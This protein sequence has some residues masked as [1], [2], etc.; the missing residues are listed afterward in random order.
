M[1]CQEQMIS[2]LVLAG[3]VSDLD[4]ILAL[5]IERDQWAGAVYAGNAAVFDFIVEYRDEFGKIPSE[6]RVLD[7]FPDFFFDRDLHPLD[8]VI[9]QFHRM[10]S[11]NLI[12]DA[13]TERFK[14]LYEGGDPGAELDSLIAEL[15]S[16]RALVS[17]GKTGRRLT[18][19]SSE[20]IQ[21]EVVTWFWS[22]GGV[23]WIP[24]ASLVV[25]AGDPGEGKGLFGCWLCSMATNGLEGF[26]TTRVGILGHED[27]KGIQR[28]RLD[29]AQS[30]PVTF[31][32]LTEA[33]GSMSA[34]KFPS[35]IDLLRQAIV[36]N[37]LGLVII[38]P[39]NS[40]TDPNIKSSDDMSVRRALQ[41][42]SM[43]AQELGCVILAVHHLS[44]GTVGQ[45]L[46]YRSGGAAAY[47]GVARQVIAL[48][49]QSGAD[50]DDEEELNARF[51]FQS[52][53]NYTRKTTA[54]LRFQIETREIEAKTAAGVPR[55]ER[56]AKFEL[57]GADDGVTQEDVFQPPKGPG[58]PKKDGLREWVEAYLD[59][60]SSVVPQ[61]ME[62]AAHA[63]GLHSSWRTI[64]AIVHDEEGWET[65]RLPGANRFEWRRPT[66]LKS[67]PELIVDLGEV[68][69]E[70][71]AEEEV[72]GGVGSR[73]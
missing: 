3:K 31:L 54:P 6:K 69:A 61:R 5:N 8:D 59:G 72:A 30:G 10:R 25:L 11:L 63:D 51:V 58:R 55:I 29:A 50:E 12:K 2:R 15:Q 45:K 18:V 53:S 67:D 44:K 48:G 26:K 19:T 17:N 22:H 49:A 62:D 34:M 37:E 46:L 47:G 70:E 52:K 16:T 1:N 65:V 66:F 73:G 39:I 4:K 38:D 71:D 13:A 42:L 41:P 20:D 35:D 28:G 33:D 27:S 9:A 60:K 43:L 57:V 56:V 32:E 64:R 24:D 40:H 68:H 36:D 23:G 21:P 7:K 14:R